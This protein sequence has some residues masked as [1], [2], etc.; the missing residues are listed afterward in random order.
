[1]DMPCRWSGRRPGDP[2]QGGRHGRQ[3]DD[4]AGRGH[5]EAGVPADLG[6][7]DRDLGGRQDDRNDAIA[8]RPPGQPSVFFAP[9][10]VVHVAGQAHDA[11]G[12]QQRRDE[13][14]ADE[15]ERRHGPGPPYRG[16]AANVS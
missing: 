11:R 4:G 3:P 14:E 6:G 13:A 9:A 7:D 10:I 5:D 1:M 15:D 8:A 16:T 2:G 12:Q